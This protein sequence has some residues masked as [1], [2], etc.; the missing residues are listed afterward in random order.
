MQMFRDIPIKRKLTTIIMLTTGIVLLLA[1][2]G[3]VTSDSL[4]FCRGMVERLSTLAEVIGTNSAA[5]L[6]FKDK[7]AAE[8][9]LS[10]LSAEPPSWRTS[11]PACSDSA[12]VARMA[13]SRSSVMFIRRIVPAPP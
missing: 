11:Y 6:T 1:S 10:A 12:R 13:F 2:A 8:E 3:F 4:S 7:Q 5:A 9:T